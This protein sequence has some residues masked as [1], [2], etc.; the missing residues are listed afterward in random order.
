MDIMA[1]QENPMDTSN[2]ELLDEW[3]NLENSYL[4]EEGDSQ[5]PTQPFY[6]DEVD[7][8]SSEDEDPIQEDSV[9][10]F[11]RVLACNVDRIKT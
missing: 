9:S 6:N 11:S 7:E 8:E 2:D 4:Y 10:N 1:L 5:K 3:G